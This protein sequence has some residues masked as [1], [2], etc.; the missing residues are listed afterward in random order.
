MAG[1]REPLICHAKK[2]ERFY[3]DINQCHIALCLAKGLNVYKGQVTFKAV[4]DEKNRPYTSVS[5]VLA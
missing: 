3:F 5:E 2:D 4:A 1:S